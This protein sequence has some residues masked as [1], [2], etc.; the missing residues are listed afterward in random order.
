MWIMRVFLGISLSLVIGL[1]LESVAYPRQYF[2]GVSRESQAQQVASVLPQ[3]FPSLTSELIK[4]PL[5]YGHYAQLIDTT[6]VLSRY[7]DLLD[8]AQLEDTI[9]AYGNGNGAFALLW[10]AGHR[11]L[12]DLNGLVI[13]SPSALPVQHED[14]SK[15]LPLLFLVST[16]TKGASPAEVKAYVKELQDNGYCNLEYLVYTPNEWAIALKIIR[17]FYQKIYEMVKKTKKIP[18]PLQELESA[19]EQKGYLDSLVEELS[20]YVKLILGLGLAGIGVD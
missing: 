20:S 4:L 2:F 13:D 1:Y 14:L 5:A 6:Q 7:D 16:N 3:V 9:V 18:E 12:P 15:D 8:F 11:L 10:A 19:S 17:I